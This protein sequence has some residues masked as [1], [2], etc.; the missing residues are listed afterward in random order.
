MQTRFCFWLKNWKPSPCS[1]N[2]SYTKLTTMTWPL[3][4]YW[5]SR[6][7]IKFNIFS[8]FDW[9]ISVWFSQHLNLLFKNSL[10]LK[11]LL[12]T[13]ILVP[14]LFLRSQGTY[15]KHHLKV[16]RVL[17]KNLKFLQLKWFFKFYLK[18]F[19]NNFP[20]AFFLFHLKNWKRFWSKVTVNFF[21]CYNCTWTK[22]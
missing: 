14:L 18:T 19:T 2:Y 12:Y 8:V 22:S 3:F 1:L 20:T 10:H 5:Y 13:E 15:K 21:F 16:F 9:N 17:W 7:F 4:K 11:Y 6:W